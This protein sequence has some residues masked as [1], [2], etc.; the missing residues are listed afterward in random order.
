[1]GY[2]LVKFQIKKVVHSHFS[3]KFQFF[4][5]I[6]Q[7]S[8]LFL[9]RLLKWH[10][11]ITDDETAL[12]ITNNLSVINIALNMISSSS[13]TCWVWSETIRNDEKSVFILRLDGSSRLHQTIFSALLSRFL[14]CELSCPAWYSWRLNVIKMLS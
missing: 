7:Y 12:Y 6:F 4:Q 13:V 14:A 3:V 8:W 9:I 11:F 2:N 10:I 5:L 1:M